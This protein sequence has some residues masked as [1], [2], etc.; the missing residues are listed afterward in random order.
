[1]RL[2][3]LKCFP[4]FLTLVVAVLSFGLLSMI[5]VGDLYNPAKAYADQ[6]KNE[7]GN[8]E[9]MNQ[10]ISE[11][12]DEY[13]REMDQLDA[14]RS[15]KLRKIE[16]EYTREFANAEDEYQ[17]DIAEEDG[18]KAQETFQE[19]RDDLDSKF[20]EEQHEI[21]EWYEEKADEIY[22]N[23]TGSN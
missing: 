11:K 15:R 13:D 16:D 22:R 3:V 21:S 6:G 20:N 14:E 7:S 10:G 9:G 5:S 12:Q 1:M 19:K 2:N 17:H 8:I 23:K 4:V 18:T